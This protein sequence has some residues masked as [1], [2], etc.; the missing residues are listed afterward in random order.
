MGGQII[1]KRSRWLS[2]EYWAWGQVSAAFI[3]GSYLARKVTLFCHLT[4][5]YM[6]LLCLV[7][8]ESFNHLF[9]QNIYKIKELESLSEKSDNTKTTQDSSCH[10]MLLSRFQTWSSIWRFSM[11]RLGRQ[12]GGWPPW[13]LRW[14]GWLGTS[15][16]WR[17]V[18][19][20][21]EGIAVSV[22]HCSVLFNM[23]DFLESLLTQ[24]T[25]TTIF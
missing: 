3:H 6:I 11:R 17:W 25:F 18:F 24:S 10:P 12:R 19:A 15:W 16:S 5:G 22:Y 2:E 20:L 4:R 7:S 13:K 21:L 8:V 1:H 14:R 23:C 9:D